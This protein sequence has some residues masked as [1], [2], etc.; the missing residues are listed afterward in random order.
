MNE[1][2]SNSW[3]DEN[4]SVGYEDAQWQIQQLEKKIRK[5]KRKK[6]GKKKGGKNK[7][8]RKIKR[9]ELEQ[10]QLKQFVIFFAYQYKAQLDQQPWWQGALS[11]TL[12]KLF[13]LATATINKLP[14]K[15]RPLYITDGSDRK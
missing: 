1:M 7:L 15:T 3:E 13:D 12:P 8:K 14:D 9:L 5:L 6:K 4:F 2:Y 10:E 11:N